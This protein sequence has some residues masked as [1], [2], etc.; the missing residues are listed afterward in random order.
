MKKE[1]GTNRYQIS[2]LL[3]ATIVVILPLAGYAE[4][5]SIESEVQIGKESSVA[6]EVFSK[7]QVLKPVGIAFDSKD[8][9]YVLHSANRIK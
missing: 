7:S 2:L 8:N 5:S 3:V 1:F 6:W 4:V 9:M